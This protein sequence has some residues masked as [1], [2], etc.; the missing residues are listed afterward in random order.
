MTVITPEDVEG[1]TWKIN[2]A[3]APDT[4]EA[5]GLEKLK[6]YALHYVRHLR[7]QGRSEL[8]IW[9]YHAMLG[10]IGHA[11]VASVEEAIFFHG[12]ARNSQIAATISG[13][14]VLTECYSALSPEVMED[15]DGHLIAQKN[16]GLIEDLLSFDAILIAGQAKSHSVAW[17]VEDL[18]DEIS[19]RKPEDANKV[20]LLEDCTTPI[21]VPGI[22]DFTEQSDQAFQR[23]ARAGA[24]LVKSTEPIVRWPGMEDFATDTDTGADTEGKIV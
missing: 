15:Q 23:F 10:G 24:H 7:R 4:P 20:Y 2:P 21:V 22:V 5:G 1:G 9:P 18:L 17:T 3:M 19:M 16:L 11:L 12:I 13:H 6:K 14:N 8:T